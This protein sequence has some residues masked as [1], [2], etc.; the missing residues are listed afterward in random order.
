MRVGRRGSIEIAPLWLRAA[1][2]LVD[3]VL[4]LAALA[5]PGVIWWRRSEHDH[6]DRLAEHLGSPR[7]VRAIRVDD[8]RALQRVTGVGAAMTDSAAWLISDAL[9]LPGQ[10]QLMRAL[11]SPT[12]G[13]H[14]A[15]LRVPMGASDF[16]ATGVPYTYD[17]QPAGVSDP[18]LA[19]F[20]IAHDEAYVL[21]ALRAARAVN[22]SLYLEAMPWSP[23]AWMKST[24]MLDNAGHTGVLLAS[25]EQPLAGYF[26]RFLQAYAAAGV[27]IDA[28]A[29]Q[30]EPN[31]PAAY[32]GMELPGAEEAAF[33]A[34]DLRPA[35]RRAGLHPAVFGWDLSWG[36][37]AAN[38]PLI[39][40]T[41][42]PARG[43][44]GLA[45]HCY[46]GAPGAMSRA[47]SLSPAATQIVD[48]CSTGA[49]EPWSS[50]EVMIAS[51]RNWAQTVSLWNL[52]LD[53]AGGPV[54]PPN[55]GCLGC[56]GVVT[57]NEATHAYTLSRDYFELGQF[58]R[59]VEP[60]AVRIAS[61]HLVRYDLTPA[62]QTVVTPGLDDVAFEN[63]DGTRVLLADDTSSLPIRF[64]VRW[65]G[66]TA[67]DTIAAGATATL[68]WR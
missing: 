65:H 67:I 27:P 51:F 11:F 12:A 56:T 5:G 47:H 9:S 13:I 15:F 58:S 16:S 61:N 50:A 31:V 60:G 62:Y 45:W 44:N 22:P 6:P 63:P 23:P 53:P 8:G 18:T 4:T 40:A 29:P 48:E 52:A 28:I 1:A 59:F 42:T 14:L 33:V 32:P 7:V 30:N 2:G 3:A 68:R 66:E 25:A 49:R 54:Q 64:A 36:P 41:R 37:L 21:P 57:V 20:S 55:S 38:N 17:D 46:Y 19:G 24:D 39:E 10:A 35:L 34:G 43:L 26:V